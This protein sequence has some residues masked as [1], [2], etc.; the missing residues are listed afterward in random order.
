MKK[1][2]T[3]K[4]EFKKKSFLK[5]LILVTG[6]HTS[7]KSMLA[8]VVA[9]LNKVEILRKIYTLDQLAIL[10]NFKKIK[11]NTAS[12]IAKHIL[13]QSYYDQLIGRNMNFRYE[14]ETSVAT[15]KD[16]LN[17]KRRLKIKRGVKVLKVHQ[18]KG[19]HM[20][21]DTHDG[22]WF[23]EFWKNLNIKNMK[24]INIYRNP[25][26]I[27]NSWINLDLGEAE[28][29]LL[30]QIPLINFKNK[31]KVFYLLNNI[32]KKYNS[33]YDC[34]IDMV[35]QCVNNEIENYKKIKNKKNIIRIDFDDFAANTK[36]FVGRIEKFLKLKRT[37]F[38]NKILIRENLPRVINIKDREK[39]RKM[40][41]SKTTAHFYN[42]LLKLEQKLIKNKIIFKI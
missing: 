27:V 2:I 12:F 3:K 33:K 42:K 21:V 41:K 15:S 7:G 26:D 28:K 14:D 13:D 40:I 16:P 36:Y 25:I 6:T 32:K 35:V 37:K 29:Q 39:K 24:I 17:Y 10:N 4:I 18:K 23:Y 22:V 11:K 31:T 1:K 5:N 9:S 20:L 19:T 30:C 34:I 38:T 8:P